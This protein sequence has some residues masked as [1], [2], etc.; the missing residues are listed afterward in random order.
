[1]QAVDHTTNTV[2]I[3]HVSFSYGEREILHDITFAIHRGDY[4]GMVGPNGAGKTTLLKIMLGLLTPSSGSVTIFGENVKRFKD[5]PKIGY[6]PQKALVFDTHFPATVEEVVLMG[7]YAK[8]GL[9]R[10]IIAEDRAAGERA[11]RKTEMWA[12]RER[13][14][15]DLSGGQQ[16]RVFI[17]RALVTDPEI[18]F[19][20]EPTTGV[21]MKSQE[22]FYTLLRRLNKES[23]VTLI[24]VSHDV[25]TVL[26][27]AMHI[28]CIDT[29]LVCHGSP[30]DYLKASSAIAVHPIDQ[31]RA[32]HY[33]RSFL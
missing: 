12:Y 1:M 32:G 21:D 16:Q 28:A 10:R 18:L 30:G 20:D 17:A 33:H 2:E 25:D 19:L 13:L 9:F 24:L 31:A 7:R 4:L 5:W 8:R 26:S 27:E 6:V 29:T 11:L 23:H 14:I 15:G 22:E 3:S